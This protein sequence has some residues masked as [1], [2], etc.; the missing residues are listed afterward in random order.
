MSSPGEGTSPGNGSG[1][2]P[3]LELA[4]LVEAPAEGF[5]GQV[6]RSILRRG[7][8]AD[9]AHYAWFSPF[10]ILLEYLG[11]VFSVLGSGSTTGDGDT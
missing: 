3:V 9:L 8:A 1:S 4:E 10:R 11:L 7:F 6:Q 5:Q 2:E